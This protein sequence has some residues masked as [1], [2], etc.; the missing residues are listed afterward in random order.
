MANVF[1]QDSTM[2]AIGEAIR[3]KTGGV[4]LIYPKDMAAQI[5]S[6]KTGAV[7]QEKTI[8]PTT[9]QQ[10]VTPDAEYDGLSKV[11]VEAMQVADTASP[12]IEV[13]DEGLI[14]ASVQHNEGYVA[15]DETATSTKQL[16]TQAAK[17]VTPATNEQV[18][19]EAGVFTTGD[20]VV[21]GDANLVPEN[22]KSG[23]SIFGVDGTH[24]GGIDVTLIEGMEI[25]L[26]FSAGDQSL[27]A[28][29]GYA[30]K[31]ATIKK[32]TTLVPQNIANGVNIAGVV[33]TLESGSGDGSDLVRYVTFLDE[34]G[35]QLYRMPVLVGD[36]CKD[37]VTHGDISKP[38]KASTNTQVFT[39][40]G[41]TSTVGGTSDSDIL[42]NITADKTVYA[43]FAASTRY[44]TVNFYDSDGVTLLKTEQF[45]Y[46]ADA[47]DYAP[48]KEGYYVSNFN[49]PVTNVTSDIDT[50]I[51][52]AE[53]DGYIQKSWAY[54][55]ESD[56]FVV[57]DKKVVTFNYEDGTSEDVVFSI[58]A[59]NQD[60]LADGSKAK[61]TFI[62]DN[63]LSNPIGYSGISTAGDTKTGGS[64][65][66]YEN[67]TLQASL[68]A[69]KETMP[70]DLR[71]VM[72]RVHRR[73]TYEDLF[74]P[75]AKN[76][77]E[78]TPYDSAG[79]AAVV[80]SAFSGSSTS[81]PTKRIR[82]KKDETSA[83]DYWTETAYISNTHNKLI[84]CYSVASTGVVTPN[85]NGYGNFYSGV[86]YPLK[87]CLLL[88]FCI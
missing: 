68:S 38:T 70:D 52:W 37:P 62:A 78:A 58:C 69:I 26:D 13:S 22:I 31:S 27:S 46:G 8:A 83:R 33:G 10:E 73:T 87:R 11:T 34:D 71:A 25:A 39:Y 51:T 14:Q 72:K 43:A 64:I 79:G 7:L 61:Y 77:N 59:V 12:V 82:R 57:G 47:R 76:L 54:I 23:V 19:V 2:A 88:A 53:S 84:G 29:E 44:Y 81:N 3:E 30:V 9:Y 21:E 66:V 15:A 50:V 85:S 35:T 49:P 28:Q 5:S 41:W 4:A 60:V 36:D 45:E 40:S 55:S 18:A 80:Y 56:E 24:E 17:A 67:D 20:I 63:L 1:I 32:P 65:I 42:K 86:F 74:I 16:P 6:I 75:S 48:D